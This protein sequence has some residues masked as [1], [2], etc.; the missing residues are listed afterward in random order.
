MAENLKKNNISVVQI[1]QIVQ[2]NHNG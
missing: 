2:E 1:S